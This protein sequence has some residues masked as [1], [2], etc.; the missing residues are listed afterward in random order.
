MLTPGSAFG[1]EGW[2]RIGY[3][4]DTAVLAKGLELLGGFLAA[5]RKEG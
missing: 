5:G 3:A 1:M 4:C 2:L